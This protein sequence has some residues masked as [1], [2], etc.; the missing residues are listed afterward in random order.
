[1]RYHRQNGS[2]TREAR[3]RSATKTTTETP[4]RSSTPSWKRTNSSTG[5]RHPRI[6]LAKAPS[7][8]STHATW[9]GSRVSYAIKASTTMQACYRQRHAQQCG[10]QRASALCSA[11]RTTYAHAAWYAPTS[12]EYGATVQHETKTTS[13]NTAML[14]RRAIEGSQYVPCF[15]LRGLVPG[16]WITLPECTAA[17]QPLDMGTFDSTDYS[18]DAIA[19]AST[20]GSGGGHSGDPRCRRFGW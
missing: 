9:A 8:A 11:T 7:S 18:N 5:P 3:G 13:T 17:N 2:T 16:A 15:W 12:T 19:T 4:Q 6:G 1:M 14:Q 20:D 10:R